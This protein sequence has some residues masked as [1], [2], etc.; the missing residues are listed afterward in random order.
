MGLC[1]NLSYLY[2]GKFAWVFC[3]FVL[4]AGNREFSPKSLFFFHW[5]NARG[6]RPHTTGTVPTEFGL[7]NYL[8][9]LV[10]AGNRGFYDNNDLIRRHSPD[11]QSWNVIRYLGN[12]FLVPRR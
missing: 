10:V 4:V 5:C 12:T 7:T 9:V 2:V 3:V 1:T 8:K 6:Q 11:R